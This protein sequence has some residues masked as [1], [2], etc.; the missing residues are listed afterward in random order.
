MEGGS[1][2]NVFARIRP[3]AGAAAATC[4][5]AAISLPDTTYNFDGAGGPA[6]SQEDVFQAVG[7][8]LCDAVLSGVNAC[9]LA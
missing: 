6:T 4:S 7:L 8:R 3:G 9:L 5:G 2:I 1:S